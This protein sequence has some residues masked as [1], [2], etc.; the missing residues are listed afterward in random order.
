MLPFELDS[1]RLVEGF[2]KD[3]IE[4]ICKGNTQRLD[5]PVHQ[6]PLFSDPDYQM[7]IQTK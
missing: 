1:S 4:S 3:A 6:S 7:Q 5:K 2:V